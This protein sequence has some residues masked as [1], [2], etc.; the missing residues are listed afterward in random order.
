MNAICK[1][2]LIL[3]GAAI[4]KACLTSLFGSFVK[5]FTQVNFPLYESYVLATCL[6]KE[7]SAKHFSLL[8]LHEPITINIIR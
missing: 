2:F 1:W 6:Q 8:M 7:L 5:I 4:D 3:I